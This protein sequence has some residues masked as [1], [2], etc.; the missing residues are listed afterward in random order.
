MPERM[1]GD[2]INQFLK[3]TRCTH[4]MITDLKQITIRNTTTSEQIMDQLTE[5]QNG[6]HNILKTISQIQKE[7]RKK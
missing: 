4:N 7:I 6:Q 3:I 2:M 1:I 5:L